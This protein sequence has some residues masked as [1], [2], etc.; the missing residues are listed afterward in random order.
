[1]FVLS[2]ALTILLLLE[3][4]PSAPAA[5][6]RYGPGVERLDGLTRLGLRA[7]RRLWV[8]TV[9]GVMHTLATV[10]LVVGIR[11]P[12]LG[13]VAAAVEAVFFGGVLVRQLRCGDRGKVLFAYGL[14]LA[15]ALAV[16]VVAALRL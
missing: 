5:L 16:L 2:T 8:V 14:F 4:V 11:H 1:V 15:W 13:A 10:A 3:V 12:L 6:T 7:G 9:L